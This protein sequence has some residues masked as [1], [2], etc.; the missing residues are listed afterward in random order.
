VD[1]IETVVS[2]LIDF[3]EAR[4]GTPADAPSNGA[5]SKVRQFNPLSPPS[6]KHTKVLAVELRGRPLAHGQVSWNGLLNAA[7]REAKARAKSASELKQFVVVPFVE[8]QKTDEGYRYLSELG[9]R[10]R[11]R[12]RTVH[13]RR[14]ATSRKSSAWHLPRPS[15]GVR[16][17]GQRSQ[18]SRVGSPPR[19]TSC[20]RPP[21]RIVVAVAASARRLERCACAL[22]CLRPT[23]PS[24]IS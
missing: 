23:W 17:K 13:G 18:A 22:S 6:L 4:D 11:G 1:N 3:Y 19:G 16:R 8:G 7:V 5:A 21:A 15:C 14:P 10:C 20:C 12:M 24:S 2:R 9:S